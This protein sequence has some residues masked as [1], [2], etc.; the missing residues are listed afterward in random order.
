M[1]RTKKQK[2]E[3]KKSPRQIWSGSLSF[4]LVNI[5]VKLYPASKE[6]SLKF[7]YL[8]KNDL[9]PIRYAKIC[10]ADGKEVPFEEVV[11]GYEFSKGDYVVLTDEDFKK[12]DLRRTKL[13]EI[14]EFVNEREI[15]DIYFEKPFYLEPEEGSA[16][17]YVLIREALKRS[18]K[19]G[20]AKYVL[21]NKEYL[22]AVKAEKNFLILSQMRFEEEIIKPSWLDIPEE[23]IKAKEIE[24]ALQL[25]DKLTEKFDPA[26]Y[27]DS[28]KSN[29][30][31]IIEEK[32][33]G[34]TPRARGK[35]PRPTRTPD[36]IKILKESLEKS[37]SQYVS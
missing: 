23:K 33:R 18:K 14:L 4:G 5:P 13:I 16:K 11:K 21:R 17:A 6:S 19:I 7:N 29:L 27:K 12:A 32:K 34:K 20:I 10:K 26:E 37:K 31:E 22:G 3:T 36:L 28:Y 30:K 24:I 2:E 1:A 25:I 8:H 9:S 15:D 35:A